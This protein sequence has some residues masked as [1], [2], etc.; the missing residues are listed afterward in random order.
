MYWRNVDKSVCMVR[1][2]S[3]RCHEACRYIA[4]NTTDFRVHRKWCV[5]SLRVK[6]K[7]FNGLGSLDKKGKQ[8]LSII[9]SSIIGG[10][11][12]A[13]VKSKRRL[14]IKEI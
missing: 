8:S 3:A 12:R 13:K 9:P 6:L 11:K 7:Y 10:T 5:L 14:I 2:G 4:F 1:M